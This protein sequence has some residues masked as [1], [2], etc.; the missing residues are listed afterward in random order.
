M[1]KKDPVTLKD[2]EDWK[3]FTENMGSISVKESDL[4]K[5]N[6]QVNKVVLIYKH[7]SSSK[8][9]ILEI[10]DALSKTKLKPPIH[11]LGEN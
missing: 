2:K 10:D 9:N 3:T 8:S 4:P 6:I 1:K 11:L 7:N 5:E